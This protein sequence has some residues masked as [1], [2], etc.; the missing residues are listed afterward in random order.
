MLSISFKTNIDAFERTLNDAEKRQLPFALA[1]ALT[2]TAR[3]D[4]KPSLDRQIDLSF[5]A[6]TPFTRR[7]IGYLRASKS[8]MVASVFI[9][10][11]QGQY[12]ELEITGGVRRPTGKAIPIPVGQRLNKYGNLP[13]GKIK[14]LLSQ[15]NVFSGRVNGRGGIWKRTKRG[16]KLLIA[17]ADRAQYRPRFPFFQTAR[18]STLA[19][20][21][22]RFERSFM[23]AMRTA[24]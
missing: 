4:V 18:S 17:W 15:P 6:P 9:K 20:F 19:H 1:R 2:Q 12:L 7:A 8:N 23:D 14:S 24:R 16:P 3:D 22:R 11:V 10:D 21:P 5:E 13:R